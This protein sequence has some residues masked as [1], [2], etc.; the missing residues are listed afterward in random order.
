MRLTFETGSGQRYSVLLRD[1]GY[2]FFVEGYEGPAQN[3]I[4]PAESEY[5]MEYKH[6][7][8]PGISGDIVDLMWKGLLASG[9]VEVDDDNVYLVESWNVGDCNGSLS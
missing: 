8:Y 9:G 7:N 2:R 6:F 1:D 3:I 4:D 5:L